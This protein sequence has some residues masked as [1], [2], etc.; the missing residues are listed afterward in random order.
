MKKKLTLGVPVSRKTSLKNFPTSP[1]R[2]FGAAVAWKA[3]T[4]IAA[5]K[6]I[7]LRD[8]SLGTSGRAASVAMVKTL[9]LLCP[10]GG[11]SAPVTAPGPRGRDGTAS[12]GAGHL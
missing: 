5:M 4:G 6:R 7:P 9:R 3:K 12:S 11:R 8:G 1:L 2:K 10:G